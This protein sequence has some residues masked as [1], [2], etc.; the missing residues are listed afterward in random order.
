METQVIVLKSI[1]LKDFK[2]IF[3]KT[4]EVEE[5]T[6]KKYAQTINIFCNKFGN[7]RLE[8]ISA[9][10]VD[11]YLKSLKELSETTLHTARS[12]LSSVFNKAVELDYLH[13]NPLSYKK[14]DFCPVVRERIFTEEQVKKIVLCQRREISNVMRFALLTGF[15]R[16]SVMNLRWDDIDT[17]TNRIYLP[18]SYIGKIYTT[19]PIFSK[20]REILEV[21]NGKHDEFIFPNLTQ[22]KRYKQHNY[23][24][25]NVA[26]RRGFDDVGM[27]DY[28]FKDI[29]T[30]FARNFLICGG[31]L[32]Q[33][34][35]MLGL[36]DLN[37]L[38]RYEKFSSNT[39]NNIDHV[40]GRVNDFVKEIG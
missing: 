40:L 13:K 9:D 34:R 20:V 24:S 10:S 23:H 22:H 31:S 35:D 25:F 29:R 36:K 14:T 2:D 26:V 7:N 12:L 16:S 8:Q 33:L 3:L 21:Q 15:K 37:Y 19:F 1:T 5:R 4:C 11:D 27:Q 39:T 30:N 38:F 32:E 28:V 6:L 17:R 18:S